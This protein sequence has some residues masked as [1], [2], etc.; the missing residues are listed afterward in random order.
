[1]IKAI[2]FDLDDTLLGNELDNFMKHYF[3]LLGQHAHTIMQ[4]QQFISELLICTRA[5]I[6]STDTSLTNRDVFWQTF[7]ERNGVDNIDELEAYFD[8]FYRETFPNLRD[9]TQ[10]RASAA[11]LVRRCLEQDLQV[12]VATNPVFPT[13][14]I[15]HRLEWA[16][17]AVS[18]FPFALVTTYSNMHSTKPHP[19]YYQEILERIGCTP[20]SA[21]MVGDSWENDMVPAA[22]LGLATYW[23]A[24]EGVAVPDTTVSI[25]A[26]GS[27]EKLEELVY[28]GWL[29][30]EMK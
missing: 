25:T 10:C 29:L 18:D 6:T 27:L 11:R 1:M 22:R 4:P 20:E 21:L 9:Q 3:A 30:E 15:E 5:M 26:H 2:L 17:L 24:D 8:L 13:I 16:G 28:S 7:A 23:I 12:V 14:A 19:S